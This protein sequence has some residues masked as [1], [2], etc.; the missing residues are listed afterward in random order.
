MNIV[1]AV[2][3]NWAIG[4]RGKQLAYIHEDLVRFRGLTMGHPVIYGRK[5]LDTFPGGEPLSGRRNMV[6]STGMKPREGLEVYRNLRDLLAV[7][8]DDSFVI[9]G[10][11]LYYRLLDKCN[12]AYVTHIENVYA[13]DRFFPNLDHHPDWVLAEKSS[14]LEENGLR[15]YYSVY[16]RVCPIY[17]S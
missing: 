16:S 2:D 9:G 3:K 5:T 11:S 14:L 17:N 12:K 7:A 6:L 4:F 10:S 13:A 8:P 15:F 1:V